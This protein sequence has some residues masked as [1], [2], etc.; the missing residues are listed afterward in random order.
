MDWIEIK[1]QQDIDNLMDLYDGFHDSC[2]VEVNYC[3]GA[4]VSED[5]RMAM[6]ENPTATVIFQRQDN[7][8]RTIE[9]KFEKAKKINIAPKEEGYTSEIL[10]AALFLHDGDFYWAALDYWDL[11]ENY[12]DD[13]TWIAA[14]RFFYRVVD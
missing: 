4:Y 7:D 5:L 14:Q 12:R 1:T 3:S 11:D 10:G 13:I 8:H 6:E 2:L 9:L